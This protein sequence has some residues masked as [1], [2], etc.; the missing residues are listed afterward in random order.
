M[1]PGVQE[2]RDPAP[3]CCLCPVSGGALKPATNPGLWC[4]TTC[5]QWIPEVSV[6][7]VMRMEPVSNIT[8][9]Q[10]ERWE[11]NCCICK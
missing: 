8:T 6:Q 3:Q 1:V 10:K 11:L 5:M 9:I 4:H 7:D 2:E